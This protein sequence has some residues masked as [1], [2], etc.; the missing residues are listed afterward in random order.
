MSVKDDRTGRLL[1]S[2][3]FSGLADA[4]DYLSHAHL[5]FSTCRKHF[6]A[7]STI[8]MMKQTRR[9]RIS[10]IPSDANSA[11]CLCFII[12]IRVVTRVAR[13]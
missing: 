4:T 7:R 6:G 2:M 10:V 13:V 1:L 11:S 12:A 8:T 9:T 5:V 3:R